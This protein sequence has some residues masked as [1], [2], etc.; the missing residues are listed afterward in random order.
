MKRHTK[1]HTYVHTGIC[2]EIEIVETFC[3][4]YLKY[5]DDFRKTLINLTGD[6]C[7]Q[8]RIQNFKNCVVGAKQPKIFFASPF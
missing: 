3:L 7:V 1:T 6:P 5:F 8:G 4:F 2:S